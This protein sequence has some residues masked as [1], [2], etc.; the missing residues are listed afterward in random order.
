[1]QTDHSATI[2]GRYVIE[3]LIAR[4]GMADVYRATDMQLGRRVEV[5][6]LRHVTSDDAST[7]RFVDEA[8]I[9]ARL[10]HP[11]LVDRARCRHP[12]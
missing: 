6:L 4:G 8:H 1:M 11:A 5:K 12:G 10:N 2:G 7:A 9:L 3:T